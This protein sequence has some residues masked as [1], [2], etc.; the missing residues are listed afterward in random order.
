[1]KIFIG[2]TNIASTMGEMR[3]AFQK[4]N[5]EV[6]I[7]VN[8]LPAIANQNISLDIISSTQINPLFRNN[9]FLGTKSVWKKAI[10]KP[11]SDIRKFLINRY[12]SKILPQLIEQHDVFIFIWS[13]ILADYSDLKLIKKAGKKI[14]F[15]FVGD[16]VRWYW[17]MK[18]EFEGLGMSPVEYG[19]GYNYTAIG[20]YRR[21]K[22]IRMAEKYA[23]LVYSKREQ[24]QLQKRPFFHWIMFVNASDYTVRDSEKEIPL[25]IHAPSNMS[26]KGS[27]YI[28]DAVNE[29]KAEGLVFDFQLVENMKFE[30]CKKLIEKADFII[31]QLFIPG[32]GRLC[33]EALSCNAKAISFMAYSIYYQGFMP[34]KQENCPIIDA[35]RHSI[36]EVLHK[37]ILQFEGIKRTEDY[38][39]RNYATLHLNV[40]IFCAELIA[41]L[42]AKSIDLNYDYEPLFY[43]EYKP[44]S[45]LEKVILHYWDKLRY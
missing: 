40:D 33:A 11:Y 38:L 29:L 44:K 24:A 23:D 5:H 32:G 37:Q 27:K 36:K 41:H 17:A 2:T 4:L 25:V 31:D 18:Q 13:S 30:E 21:I 8:D 12:N 35:D 9:W 10:R 39:N 34:Q 20:L 15:I 6:T 28:I 22:R 3:H 1:M 42:N 19:K 26:I 16:D 45:I 7:M 43:K 14:V